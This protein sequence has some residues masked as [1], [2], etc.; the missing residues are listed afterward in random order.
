MQKQ[1]PQVM[2][3]TISAEPSAI[4]HFAREIEHRAPI[5][6]TKVIVMARKQILFRSAAREKIFR[7]ATQ[8]ADAIRVTLGLR[9][10]SAL[11]EKKWGSPVVCDDRVTIVKEFDLK[12]PEENL[13]ARKEAEGFDASR[14]DY[15]DL[16]Q[17]GIIDPT[18]VI[19]V[20]LENAMSV[21]SVLTEATMTEIPEDR[22][23]RAPEPELAM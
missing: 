20:A 16:I 23:E 12:D 15:V 22:K 5:I 2:L 13:G 6:R 11:F 17:A 9:S 3:Q 7:G 14:K 8:L 10:K 4:K 21:A 18:K 19:R 1:M